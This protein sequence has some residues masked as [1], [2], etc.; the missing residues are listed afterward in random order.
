MHWNKCSNYFPAAQEIRWEMEKREMKECFRAG[1]QDKICG[2]IQNWI[3]L[4]ILST[5]LDLIKPT[6]RHL[7]WPCCLKRIHGKIHLTSE[8]LIQSWLFSAMICLCWYQREA[9]LKC[10]WKQSTWR[11]D[12]AKQLSSPHLLTFNYHYELRLS[13]H[14]LLFFYSRVSF[15]ER[16]RFRL[17][18]Q[19]TWRKTS[20]LSSLK[21]SS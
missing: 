10:K 1:K 3:V 7:Q 19:G 11:A 2:W 15:S 13:H 8:R 18:N 4:Q 17:D 16:L 9:P 21:T 12:S 14:I 20:Q 5:V 6:K